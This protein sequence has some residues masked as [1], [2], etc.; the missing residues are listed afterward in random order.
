ME[1]TVPRDEFWVNFRSSSPPGTTRSTYV[2]HKIITFP[3]P[4][5]SSLFPSEGIFTPSPFRLVLS[6][7][8]PS[9]SVLSRPVYIPN[10]T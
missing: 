5:S 9:H 6:R 4:S 2:E 8:V 3:S 1:C 10:D 7:P